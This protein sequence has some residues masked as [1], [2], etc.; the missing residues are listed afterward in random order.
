MVPAHIVA[1]LTT[2]FIVA[3]AASIMTASA[4]HF[5]R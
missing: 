4:G 5:I 2:H 1:T 3:P